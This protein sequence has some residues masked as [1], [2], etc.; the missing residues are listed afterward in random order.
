MHI[1]EIKRKVGLGC[2]L[3][4]PFIKS[5]TKTFKFKN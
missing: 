3:T 4:V 1:N 5:G 2:K